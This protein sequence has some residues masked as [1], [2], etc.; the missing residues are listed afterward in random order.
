MKILITG[1]NGFIGSHLCEKLVHLGHD[2]TLI[3]SKFNSNSKNI[4]CKKITKDI[5]SDDL[6]KVVQ[7]NELTIHLA[8]VSRV[9]DCQENPIR[10]FEVNVIGVLKIVE[11]LKSSN[12]KVI[13]SSSREVYG[14]PQKTPVKEGDEKIPLTTYGTTKL[15]GEHI[16]KTY[17]KIYGLDYVTLRLANV[18]G[19]IRDLP[20]RVIPRFIDLAK[21]DKPFTINGGEQIIDFT[22]IDNVVEGI[23]SVV[24]NIELGNKNIYGD[25]YNFSSGKGTS[26]KDLAILIKKILNSNSQLDINEP[27]N[28]DVQKFIGNYFKAKNTFSFNPTYTLEQGLRNYKF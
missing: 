12:S 21:N 15:S 14:E 10:C 17:R 27:R 4:S 26:V 20:Q 11:A 23:S 22:F 7:E 5:A 6:K 16:L 19:S 18:Y 8:A 28:Y 1:G 25:E 9:D 2:L 3:D 24:K 13:F